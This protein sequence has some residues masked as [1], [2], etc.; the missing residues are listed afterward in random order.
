MNGFYYFGDNLYAS[1]NFKAA[2]TAMVRTNWVRL[3]ECKKSLQ[4]I[5]FHKNFVG[6]T[7]F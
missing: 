3:R 6:D 4:K 1:G 2:V 5:N 7:E